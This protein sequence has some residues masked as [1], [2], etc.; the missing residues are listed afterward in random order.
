MENNKRP[1]EAR[2]TSYLFQ[3]ASKANIPLSGTF[4]LSPVCN[5][6]CKMCYVRK[7]A[8]E[9]KSS[10][11]TMMTAEEWLQLAEEARRMGLLYILLTGGEPLLWPDFWYLYEKLCSMGFLISINTNGSLIDDQ[12]IERFCKNPPVRIN[13]TLYGASDETYETLCGIKGAYHKVVSAIRKLKEKGIQVKLNGSL[14][15]DN[16]QDLDACIKFAEESQLI[17]ESVTYMFPPLRRDRTLVGKNERFTPFDSAYYSLRSY[18]LQFGEA[19][20]RK[21]LEMIQQGAVPPPG[22]DENCIDPVDGRIRCRA[23]KASFWVTWNGM[24]TP[25]GMMPEPVVEIRKLPDFATAWKKLVTISNNLKLSG[26]CSSCKNR[27]LCHSCAAMAMAETGTVSG[28]PLY[29]CETVDAMKQ[30][31]EEELNNQE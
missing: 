5:F 11:E 22:L 25:C 9:V 16:I 23:G 20:Y 17:Y 10:G 19:F 12:A 27:E 26:T 2:M 8:Q 15:P 1:A 29:L 14:T 6:S 28:I 30:I 13:I 18:R 21:R 4:E 7:T 3:K 24:M 31:A